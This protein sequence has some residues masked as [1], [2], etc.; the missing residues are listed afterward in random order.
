MNIYFV[1]SEELAKGTVAKIQDVARLHIQNFFKVAFI[2]VGQTTHATISIIHLAPH[3]R[4]LP[5][6][7]LG[8]SVSRPPSCADGIEIDGSRPNRVDLCAAPLRDV[9]RCSD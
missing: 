7:G 5:E 1:T 9:S 8:N 2:N 6:I 4:I 3:S